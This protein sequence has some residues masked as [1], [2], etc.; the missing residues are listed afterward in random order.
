MAAPRHNFGGLKMILK[1]VWI[2]KRAQV[3]SDTKCLM[4]C[5]AESVEVL[6]TNSQI[7]VN[8]NLEK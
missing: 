7:A 2:T 8:R 5:H 4:T 6:V 3:R 1:G